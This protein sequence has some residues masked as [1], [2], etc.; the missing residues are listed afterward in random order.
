VTEKGSS[1]FQE[2]CILGRAGF[3]AR[4]VLLD[5]HFEHCLSL[6]TVHS[7]TSDLNVWWVIVNVRELLG[8]MCD[9]LPSSSSQGSR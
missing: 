6:Q 5:G 8:S 2:I 4:D 7:N 1:W 3:E 9:S